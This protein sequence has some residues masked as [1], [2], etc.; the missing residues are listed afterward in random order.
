MAENKV[1]SAQRVLQVLEYFDEIQ[2]DASVMDI[3]RALS[4][5]QSSTTEL[6]KTLVDLGYLSYKVE[7][8]RYMPTHR[9]ALLGSWIQ[10]QLL[11]G[12]RLIRMMEELGENTHET[13]I[14]GEYSGLSVR[15]IY[16]VQSRM[17]MRLH[18]GP[19]TVRPL[20]RSG[21]GQLFLSSFPE[22][23]VKTLLKRINSERGEDEPIIEYAKLE[24]D[25]RDIRKKG[26][27]LFTNGVNPGAGILAMMLP[28]TEDS[29]PLAI[30]IGGLA[31]NIVRNGPTL[32]NTMRSA[33]RRH[34]T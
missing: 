1:K 3:S 22:D 13:V 26:Y 30:G 20:A 19:G 8:R 15:Y 5:P 24:P 34:L 14:L 7:G 2:R 11:S 33:I 18:V 12:G 31:E 10:S 9:V 29:L 25:L 16:V 27:H 6:L 23:L 4:M 21:I 17:A 28:E 32:V